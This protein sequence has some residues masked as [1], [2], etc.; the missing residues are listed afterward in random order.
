M[1]EKIKV[2]PEKYSEVLFTWLKMHTNEDALKATS[3]YIEY[4]IP[5]YGGALKTMSTFVGDTMSFYDRDIKAEFLQELIF[6]YSALICYVSDINLIEDDDRSSIRA[7]FVEKVV[8]RCGSDLSTGGPAFRAHFSEKLK[9]YSSAI[10]EDERPKEVS[11]IFIDSL[12]D[13]GVKNTVKSR[14]LAAIS[15]GIFCSELKE[16]LAKHE[17]ESAST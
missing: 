12:P 9:E 1:D 14:S 7:S 16:T 11:R 8:D 15:F 4:K 3:K 10:T 17:I 13:S 6:V 2:T 5:F